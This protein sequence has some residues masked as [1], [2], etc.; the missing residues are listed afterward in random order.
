MIQILKKKYISIGRRKQAVAK[1][2]LYF[3]NGKLIINNQLGSY[4]LKKNKTYLNILLEPLNRLNLVNKFN[5]IIS[6]KGG[7]LSSQVD[8]IKLAIARQLY[9]INIHNRKMLKKFKF[10]TCNSKIK[11]RK[12]YGLKKARKA[13]QYSKR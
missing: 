10:L 11:E 12:K 3:G 13:S 6:V 5:I 1:A 8:A 7:G 4:Y 9:K 2:L